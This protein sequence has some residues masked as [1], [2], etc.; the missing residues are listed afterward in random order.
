MTDCMNESSVRISRV[1]SAAI[2]EEIGEVL[3]TR[4][5]R[6]AIPLPP[7]LRALME[8]MTRRFSPRVG[9]AERM[10]RQ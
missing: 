9:E 2:C 3:R 8:T 4:L 10:F 7:E 5:N 6:Q 1:H